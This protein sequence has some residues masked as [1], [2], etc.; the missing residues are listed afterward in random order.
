MSPEAN[1]IRALAEDFALEVLAS[2]D[3]DDF[4]E[5]DFSSLGQAVVYLRDHEEGPGPAL[6]RGRVRSGECLADRLR[7]LGV[8]LAPLHVG[9]DA[10][11]RHQPNLVP[12]T[13]QLTRPVMARAADTTLPVTA[14]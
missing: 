6:A 5:A 4:A 3:A 9:L 13:D 12:E 1:L 7:I 10:G 11:R 8:G 2:Y 14:S